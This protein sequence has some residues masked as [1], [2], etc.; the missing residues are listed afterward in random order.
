MMSAKKGLGRGFDSLIPTDL[1]DDSF[2]PNSIYD[3][4]AKQD[5]KVSQEKTLPLSKLHANPDQPRRHF[6]TEALEELA[7]SIKEHGIIQ[8]IVV[9]PK[10]DSYQIV[11]GERRYRASKLAGLN[12]VPVIVRT[13]SAQNQLE[14][15]LIENIQRRDLNSI[16][17]ATSYAKLRDQF[18]LTNDQI[19]QRVHKSSSAVINTMRLLKL[20]KEVIALIADGKLTEGQAR[21]LIGQDETT[22]ASIIEKII[23]EEW[24]ARK[25]EQY[26]V[27]LKKSASN[28]DDAEDG[29]EVSELDAS[30][31]A[32]IESLKSRLGVGVNIRTN[33]KGA[34]KVVISFKSKEDLDR[35]KNLLG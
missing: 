32:I 22:I 30:H 3:P 7:A 11:A 5:E 9:T 31:Q 19:A 14:I 35:I 26:V 2:D 33:A 15:S 10:G 12:D 23:T 13:L 24:S 25:I 28:E 1:I 6:D 21:P 16:E 34:G 4:T 27:N 8:P 20:P 17:T 29:K 18:N